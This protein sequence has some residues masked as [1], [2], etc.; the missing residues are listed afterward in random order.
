[1][2]RN[3]IRTC[4]SKLHRSDKLFYNSFRKWRSRGGCCKYI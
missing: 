3:I 4:V 2:H 1:M